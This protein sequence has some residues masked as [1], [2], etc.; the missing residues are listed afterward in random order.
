MPGETGTFPVVRTSHTGQRAGTR[1][2]HPKGRGSWR[3]SDAQGC[4]T[5]QGR[6]RTKGSA[7]RSPSREAFVQGSCSGFPSRHQPR[8]AALASPRLRLQLNP[9]PDASWIRNDLSWSQACPE[10]QPKPFGGPGRGSSAKDTQN[11]PKSE[12]SSS[13]PDWLRF[14]AGIQLQPQPWR[15]LPSTCQGA[16]GGVL[17]P[18]EV[19]LCQ[20]IPHHMSPQSNGKEASSRRD[21]GPELCVGLPWSMGAS[22]EGL[23]W[24]RMAPKACTRHWVWLRTMEA[25]PALPC[26]EGSS[27][28]QPQVR[29]RSPFRG[30]FSREGLPH[31][32]LLS[33]GNA[34]AIPACPQ[35]VPAPTPVLS[36]ATGDISSLLLPRLRGICSFPTLKSFPGSVPSPRTLCRAVSLSPR[37]GPAAAEPEVSGEG[38]H[39]A[40]TGRGCLNSSLDP[41]KP[42]GLLQP[43]H[44][45]KTLSM[46]GLL[47]DSHLHNS[48]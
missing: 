44:P 11:W 20:H 16:G 22:S 38:G 42:P 3:C 10:A 18:A 6:C 17:A 15:S 25:A 13:S 35:H 32:Q 29:R 12:S 30:P 48:P 36:L 19:L 14:L 1:Q 24:A 4:P 8:G 43:C 2:G 41:R 47:P 31:S 45:L 9:C 27:L 40:R 33:M 23:G 37:P 28:C 34:D 26:K 39:G 7:P 21:P 5:V 46:P